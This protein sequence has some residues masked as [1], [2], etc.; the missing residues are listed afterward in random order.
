MARHDEGAV[1]DARRAGAVASSAVAT[2]VR[3]S[4]GPSWCVMIRARPISN[5][6]HGRSLA[7]SRPRGGRAISPPWVIGSARREREAARAQL[8]QPRSGRRRGRRPA[9]G[10]CA[11]VGLRSVSLTSSA[12]SSSAPGAAGTRPARQ[13]VVTA[14]SRR[15][16]SS[17]RRSW[18]ASRRCVGASSQRGLEG[19]Q[20]RGGRLRCDAGPTE[21]RGERWRSP[22]RRRRRDRRGA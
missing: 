3:R 7:R 5:R 9:A 17:S 8:L 21:P 12:C 15:E 22:A 10:S 2:V 1:E 20:A 14:A 13:A 6:L 18:S 4:R 19:V 11:R 16:S